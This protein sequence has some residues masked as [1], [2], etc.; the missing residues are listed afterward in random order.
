MIFALI[1]AWI[2]TLLVDYNLRGA[3]L[4]DRIGLY[5]TIWGF[6]IGVIL[7]SLKAL[8]QKRE[9]L[10]ESSWSLAGHQHLDNLVRNDRPRGQAGT[11]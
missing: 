4:S 8:Y 5:V 7:D 11:G 2:L 9:A 10:S 6:A 1:V 3:S